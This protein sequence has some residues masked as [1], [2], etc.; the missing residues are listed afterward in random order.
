LSNR[1]DVPYVPTPQTVVEKMLE[2]A[3]VG[4]EDVVYDLGA[5]DGG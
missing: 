3:Q 4:P 2:S 1:P 5:G